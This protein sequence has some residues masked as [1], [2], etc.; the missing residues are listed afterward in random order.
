[1]STSFPINIRSLFGM[2]LSIF[3]LVLSLVQTPN[4]GKN[5]KMPTTP[6]DFT[7]AVRFIVF[8]D[9]HNKNDRVRDMIETTY[10]MFENDEKYPGLDVICFCGDSTSVGSEYDMDRFKATL[11]DCVRE[12]T[13]TLIILGNHELK[14]S[15]AR[16]YYEKIYGLY[17]DRHITVNGFH[18]IGLSNYYE[19]VYTAGTACWAK[20][21][22]EKA[23]AD[24]PVLPV[25]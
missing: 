10:A 2:F 8:T 5:V 21:E 9:S 3:M 18:F 12:G 17:P 20:E 6:E 25:F 23:I 11:D 14:N 15:N 7:P 13:E 16:A 22:L 19:N 24:N 1:M 4:S